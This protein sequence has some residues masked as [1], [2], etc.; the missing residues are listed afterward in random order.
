MTEAEGRDA[1]IKRSESSSRIL[2]SYAYTVGVLLARSAPFLT[3]DDIR[4][5]M[6][7]TALAEEVQL[8]AKRNGNRWLGAVIK[9]LKNDG[10]IG[11]TDSLV[12]TR[13][14]KGHSRVWRS[15]LYQGTKL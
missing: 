9:K 10:F 5:K 12:N 4:R 15:L 2:V 6:L 11:P 1:G 3:S 13:T 7:E 8:A 14:H